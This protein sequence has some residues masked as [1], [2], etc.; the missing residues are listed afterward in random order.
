MFRFAFKNLLV[1][2]SRFLLIIISII[3]STSIGLI[4]I[5]ISNQIKDG[6]IN[7]TGYYD[8]IIG[9]AGSSSQL[10]LNTLF[11]TD[12][13]L[14]TISY[15]YYENLK[16]DSRVNIAIPMAMGDNYKNSKI[17]GTTG[18]FLKGKEYLNGYLFTNKFEAVIGYN[19]AKNNN[20]K[21]G[22][23]FLGSHGISESDNGHVHENKPYTIVGILD[24]TNTAYDNVIF[25]KIES[26]WDVHGLSSNG[27]TKGV[28]YNVSGEVT[29]II[30]KSK[31]LL[32]QMTISN[33]YNTVAGLQAINPATVIRD[34]LSNVDLT[35]QIVY[36]LSF[37]IFIM[38]IVIIYIITLLNIYDTRKDIHLMRLLGISQKK[39]IAIFIIQNI[40]LSIISIS[41][42]LAIS[43]VL[44]V[45]IN[46]ITSN[47]G[48]VLNVFKMYSE[49]CIILI[50]VAI[51]CLLPTVLANLKLFK[52]DVIL[53]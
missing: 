21:I 42:S 45:S 18:D 46:K 51:I 47:M 41:I 12:K 20:L 30:I 2:K 25:V 8:T 16:L 40:I 36:I 32:D 4:A 23:I 26:V 52:K 35:K 38:A 5:N 53:D 22:D 11:F 49:E 7:T 14:G 9:P 15:N 50:I 27:Q 3:I 29:A 43:R 10:A 6:V 33:E 48:I 31:S 1:R 37:V 19:V 17:I 24:K 39:I 34:I 28:T 13:P 44:L